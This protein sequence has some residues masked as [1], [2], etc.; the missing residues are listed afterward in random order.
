MENSVRILQKLK[1][2]LPSDPAIPFL[3]LSPKKLKVLL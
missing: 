1:I 2:E 3:G